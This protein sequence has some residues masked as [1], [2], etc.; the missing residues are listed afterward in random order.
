MKREVKLVEGSLPTLSE[1]Q[2]LARL[3]AR[4][5][6]LEGENAELR[7]S[8]AS[9]TD[10]LRERDDQIARLKNYIVELETKIGG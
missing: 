6:E 8:N 9:L 1:Q 10:A 4:V 5:K 3:R 7:R 2:Q